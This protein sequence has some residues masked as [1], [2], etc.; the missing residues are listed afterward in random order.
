VD[1]LPQDSDLLAV[2]AIQAALDAGLPDEAERW[3]A[4]AVA[5]RVA[6]PGWYHLPIGYARFLRGDAAGALA[7]LRLGPQGY[8]GLTA[9]RAACEHALGNV[10][11][12]RA[13]A[14]RLHALVP[15]FSTRAYLAASAFPEAAAARIREGFDAAGLPA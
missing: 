13:G 15:G 2:A 7:A 14:E 1:R 9:F 12:A 8:P 4:R 5:L 10:A 6:P 11:A 3:A